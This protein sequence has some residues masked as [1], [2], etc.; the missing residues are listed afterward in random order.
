LAALLKEQKSDL[1]TLDGSGELRFKHCKVWEFIEKCDAVNEKLAMLTFF[2][3]G[4]T[5][6][7]TEFVEH[8]Y[9]N[10]TRPRTVFRDHETLWLAVRWLKT[11]T[12]VG[13]ET[14]IPMKCYPELSK[15]LQCYLLVVHP[16]EAEFINIVKGPKHYQI[17]MEYLWT[18]KGCALKP[19]QMY[20]SI[21]KFTSKYFGC[22]IG[23]QEYCQISVEIGRVFIGSEFQLRLEEGFDVIA[24]QAGHTLNMACAHYAAE[25]GR[26]CSMPSDLLL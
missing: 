8:K 21:K 5:S 9:A 15:Q 14:F 24:S 22:S 13:K 11:E 17:S 26:H 12:L 4:Q 25:E 20:E 10:S 7:V 1:A 2:T 16:A 6:R 23:V 19:E 3:A 18:K